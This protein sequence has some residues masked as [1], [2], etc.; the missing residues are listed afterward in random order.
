MK[1]T[2]NKEKKEQ[3][4]PEVPFVFKHKDMYLMAISIIKGEY[5]FVYL[6]GNR[7]GQQ[8]LL[9]YNSIEDMLDDDE[10]IDAELIIKE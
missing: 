8:S 3:E 7:K 2:I 5:R 1:I 6:N 10:I 9:T 4:I